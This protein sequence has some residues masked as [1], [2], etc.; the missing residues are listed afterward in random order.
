MGQFHLPP[1]LAQIQGFAPEIR[2]KPENPQFSPISDN[3]IAYTM[4]NL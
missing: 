4:R 2:K 3:L 1:I